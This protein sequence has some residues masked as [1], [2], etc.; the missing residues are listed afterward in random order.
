MKLIE[1]NKDLELLF[2]SIRMS[3]PHEHF[4]SDEEI[5]A[6]FKTAI[7]MFNNLQE[8]YW[9]GIEKG[10]VKYD[11]YF[12]SKMDLTFSNDKIGVINQL[13]R[14]WT[15]KKT[16]TIEYN[17]RGLEFIVREYTFEFDKDV[18]NMIVQILSPLMKRVAEKK[19]GVAFS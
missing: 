5:D 18:L 9:R 14:L 12:Q 13:Y 2:E 15:D 7:L 17:I 6:Y 16:T 3:L 19:N 10:E 1:S 11:D 8:P 4:E